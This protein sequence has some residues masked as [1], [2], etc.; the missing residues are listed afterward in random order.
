MSL[1]CQ[2]DRLI[3]VPQVDDS[4]YMDAPRKI[5]IHECKHS[6]HPGIGVAV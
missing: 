2:R 3:L 1:P 4:I 6:G 5:I